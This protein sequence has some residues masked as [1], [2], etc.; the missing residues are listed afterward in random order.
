[1]D[2]TQ[3]VVETVAL[4]EAYICVYVRVYVWTISGDS[5]QCVLN[6]SGQKLVCDRGTMVQTTTTA[7]VKGTETAELLKVLNYLH[8][9]PEGISIARLH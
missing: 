5:A 7:V 6:F 2:I 9:H 4:T 8:C 3:K 1:M